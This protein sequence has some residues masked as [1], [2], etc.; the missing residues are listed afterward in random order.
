MAIQGLPSTKPVTLSERVATAS[1]PTTTYYNNTEIPLGTPPSSANASEV[2]NG[3]VV[4]SYESG[5]F[6]YVYSAAQGTVKTLP[7]HL[8]ARISGTYPEQSTARDVNDAGNVT[9]ISG[10]Q[11][12]SQPTQVLWQRQT[13]SSYKVYPLSQIVKVTPSPMMARSS[14][15]APPG[16]PC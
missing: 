8:D 13:D 2:R 5:R 12:V 14:I 1:T 6:A 11:S 9:G 15:N 16:R 7:N 10:A 4:G 3:R